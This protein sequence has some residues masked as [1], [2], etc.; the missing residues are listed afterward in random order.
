M[1][2]NDSLITQQI[3]VVKSDVTVKAAASVGK[4][5]YRI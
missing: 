5:E 2:P 1:D 3:V 4:V